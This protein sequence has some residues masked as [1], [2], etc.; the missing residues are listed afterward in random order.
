MAANQE[1]ADLEKDE[2]D[3][4]TGALIFK[5]KQVVDVMTELDECFLLALESTLN[6]ETIQEISERGYSRIPV[7]DGERSNIVHILFTKDLMFVDPDDNKPLEEVCKFYNNDVYR[8]SKESDLKNIFDEFKS[9]HRGHMAV[10][11]TD[12]GK[13]ANEAIGLVTLEDIIEEIIQQEIV[14]ESDE[15]L[16]NKSQKRRPRDKT[17]EFKQFFGDNTKYQITVTPQMGLAVFQ[18]TFQ[19]KIEITAKYINSFLSS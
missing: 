18:V 2:M 16:D 14:D 10:V 4:M 12:V 5:H 3:M 11:Q 17:K 1:N 15:F 6:F 7:Y 13:D 19:T 9:A 8:I